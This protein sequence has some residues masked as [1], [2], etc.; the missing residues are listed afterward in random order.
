MKYLTP[1]NRILQICALLILTIGFNGCDQSQ[2]TDEI[3]PEVV[4]EVPDYAKMIETD[5]IITFDPET[6]EESLEIVENSYYLEVESFPVFGDCSEA[7]DSPEAIKDCSYT[8]LMMAIYQNIKYPEAA[9][10]AGVEGTVH[11]GFRLSP[12]GTMEAIAIEKGS[13]AKLA[14]GHT[15]SPEEEA[16]YLALDQTALAATHA[17]DGSWTPAMIDGESVRMKLVLPISFKLED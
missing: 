12:N 16:G 13:I 2:A 8:N 4:N 9:H 6:F 15:P 1:K 5:T 10:K 11:I 3:S 14:E 17:L 7:E